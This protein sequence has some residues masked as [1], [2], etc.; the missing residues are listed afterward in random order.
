MA[1]EKRLPLSAR[2]VVAMFMVALATSGA[3]EAAGKNALQIDRGVCAVL[4]LPDG[5]QAESVVQL[6]QDTQL[7]VY[8]QSPRADEVAAVRKAAETAGVLGSR[9]FVDLGTWDSVHLADNLADVV[10]VGQP[11]RVN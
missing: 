4:G 8:F 1:R 10:V 3:W 11:A 5:G 9:V 2:A 6:T 7:R